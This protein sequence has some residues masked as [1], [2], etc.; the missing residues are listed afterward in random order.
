MAPIHE[1]VINKINGPYKGFSVYCYDIIYDGEIRTPGRSYVGE[2]TW[3]RDYI[4]INEEEYGKLLPRVG[5]TIIVEMDGYELR[6]VQC[7]KGSIRRTPRNRE[8]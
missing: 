3:G 8:K 4:T 2:M 7:P 6:G 5:D 1:R